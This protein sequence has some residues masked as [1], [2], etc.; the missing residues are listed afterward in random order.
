MYENMV[1]WRV[2][3]QETQ[4]VVNHLHVYSMTIECSYILCIRIINGE[5][6]CLCI[7]IL[8]LNHCTQ[9]RSTKGLM[10]YSRMHFNHMF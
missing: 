10:K 3:S 8:F 5:Y 4:R 1:L 6:T 9:I 7:K 2:K